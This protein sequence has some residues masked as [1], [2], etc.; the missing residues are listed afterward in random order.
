MFDTH[1][2]WSTLVKQQL[3]LLEKKWRLLDSFHLL[4]MALLFFSLN[5]PG[6]NP[7]SEK[8]EEGDAT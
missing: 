4:Q 6:K 3:E 5:I 7:H 2:G 1:Q 8:E